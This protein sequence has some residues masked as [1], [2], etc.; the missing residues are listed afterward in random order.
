[1]SSMTV[2]GRGHATLFS[3]FSAGVLRHADTLELGAGLL[4]V[5]VNAVWFTWAESRHMWPAYLF[6]FL[7][8][9]FVTMM[10][11]DAMRRCL[12]DGDF[13]DDGQFF[14]EHLGFYMVV[15]GLQCVGSFILTGVYGILIAAIFS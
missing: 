15:I 9:G 10:I 6:F 13:D 7:A 5:L 2:V 4:G 3:L 14:G 12:S 11:R 8:L 1:M